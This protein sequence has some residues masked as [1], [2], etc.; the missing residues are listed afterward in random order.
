MIKKLIHKLINSEDKKTVV[1]NFFSLSVL[2]GL[3]LLLPL[4]TYPYLVRVLN[5]EEYGL[6]LLA[7][8]VIYYFQIF[9][10]YSFNMTATKEISLN[11]DNEQK[12]HEIF[13]DVFSTKIFLLVVSFIA[14]CLM[15]Y[16][17]P[18]FN[19]NWLV[20]MLTFGNVV[21]LALFPVWF[22]Q[23]IQKM[24][25]I[26]YIN[27]FS[28]IVF[29]GAIFLFVKQPEDYWLAPLFTACGYILAGIISLIYVRKLF[30]IPFKR[31]P[32]KKIKKQIIL[33][34]YLF[35][36]E[37]KISL[38]TNTNTLLLGFISGKVT[39][40]YFVSAEKL[41]RAIG[42]ICVPLSL[43]LFPHIS[44]NILK[45]KEGTYKDIVKISKVGTLLFLAI[46]I[47]TFIFADWIIDIIYGDK[48]QNSVL[49][50]RI[51]LFIPISTFIDNMFGKQILLT[52]GKDNLYFKVISA[53]VVLNIM[54]NLFLT[55]K[56]DYKGT[57]VALLLTHIF[58][59]IGMYWY[60]RREINKKITG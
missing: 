47:P 22:F 25:Y 15:L 33:G 30:K 27:F 13:N 54:L 21:G 31:Q 53:A 42:N 58:I 37:L 49:I 6:I 24:K 51:L 11:A 12:L 32:F 45:D 44:K 10:E 23:G 8:V 55:F 46:L 50:F 48:M 52:L 41:A 28:K 34:R 2:Q 16:L 14:F 35:L 20:Y 60:A 4:F 17:V 59:N 1:K 5:E 40:G 26:T 19:E 3:N 18:F 56:Y 29:T 43:A 38:F 7:A 9:T 36:S 57:A 39:V